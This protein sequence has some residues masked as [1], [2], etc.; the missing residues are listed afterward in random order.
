[1]QSFL[2]FLKES[3]SLE[4]H[5][6]LNP[7]LWDGFKLKPEVRQKLLQFAETWRQY[8]DIPSRLVQDIIMTGGNANYNYTKNSDIDVHLVVDKNSIDTNRALVDEL[9]QSKKLLWSLTHDVKIY[10]YSLEP[11]AQDLNE[12]IPLN[13]GVYSLKNNVW[14]QKPSNLHL[15]FEDDDL[16]KKKVD[17]YKSLIDHMIETK[18]DISSFE[19]LKKK[20]REMRASAIE[21]A[22]EFSFENLVFKELRNTGYLDKM[23]KYINSIED[24]S[25]SL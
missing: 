21:K 6:E 18:A 15:N 9:L 2:D 3:I 22:G 13:Q 5:D 24:S 10:G 20:L 14:I 19:K 7:K 11:Y 16:L 12:K 1:M 17:H 23:T 25:L 4:Y 8:A